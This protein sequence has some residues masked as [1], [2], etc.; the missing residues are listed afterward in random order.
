MTVEET[1]LG[2]PAVRVAKEP[3]L[4][5]AVSHC[6]SKGERKRTEGAKDG[7]QLIDNYT[8]AK[9]QFHTSALAGIHASTVSCDNAHIHMPNTQYATAQA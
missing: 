8:G 7:L 6:V 1:T 5:G 2:Y 4:A 9:E 3:V